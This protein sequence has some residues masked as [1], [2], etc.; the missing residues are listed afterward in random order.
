MTRLN[1]M[2]ATKKSNIWLWLVLAATLSLTAWTALQG[3]KTEGDDLI[4]PVKHQATQKTSVFNP[5]QA[6]TAESA[7]KPIAK[8]D[9]EQSTGSSALNLSSTT[10]QSR[11]K[12]QAPPKDL[13]AV[14]SWMPPPPKVKPAPPPAPVAPPSP[15][16]FVGKLENSPQGDLIFL[17]VNNKL[18]SVKCGEKIDGFWRLDKEDNANLYMTYLPLNLPQTQSKQ[19][20]TL[21]QNMIGQR[22]EVS[23]PPTE[24]E[25]LY[26]N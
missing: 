1:S 4:E 6:V 19:Q 3:D 5:R 12:L 16:T 18:H 21:D 24:R 13:F 26:G 14:H 11:D 17:L 22:M 25:V 9:A 23:T 7:A 20:K 2:Q 15:F 8:E 10:A